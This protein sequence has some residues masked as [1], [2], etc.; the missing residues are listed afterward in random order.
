[1]NYSQI[2][3]GGKKQ[4]DA[5]VIIIDSTSV[6]IKNSVLE[7][8]GES[9]IKM[10]NSSSTLEN[11]TIQN[12]NSGLAM[13]IIGGS[14]TIKNSS[15]KNTYSGVFI[16]EGSTA[17]FDTNNFEGID[18]LSGPILV[19]S[20][21]PTFRNNTA[22]NNVLNGIYLFGTISQNWTMTKDLPY[23]IANLKVAENIILTIEPEVLI[24]FLTNGKL[25]IYGT[26]KAEGNSNIFTSLLDDV[27]GDT[28]NDGSL[29]SPSGGFWDQLFFASSSQNSIIQNSL[30][31]YGGGSGQGAVYIKES[32]AQLK[33]N[34]FR[35]NGPGYYSLYMEN[36][37]SSVVE[38]SVFENCNV[39]IRIIEACPQMQNLNFNNCN[40]T[41]SRRFGS[42]DVNSTST[43]S[44]SICS[45]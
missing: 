11:S 30:I 29:T 6:D 14:P 18:Y 37:S 2:R 5:Y 4:I 33:N 44:S 12:T 3:Y 10:I 45:P 35:A 27:G 43:E 1:M 32:N 19:E 25:D 22:S 42:T 38:N 8:F 36:S 34:T 39:A 9:G 24:K 21:Y 26:L 13:E 40:Y 31:S 15:F 41:Y 23:L 28:N 16:R 7:N 17:L 20:S